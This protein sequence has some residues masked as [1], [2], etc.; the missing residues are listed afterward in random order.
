MILVDTWAWIALADRSDANRGQAK[1]HHR[2][3]TRNRQQ[4]ATTDYV[5]GETITALYDVL[6]PKKARAF[7]QAVLDG[8]DGGTVHF[9]HL[10]P[11]QF[12]RA[13]Q[14][15]QKYHDK[16]AISFVDFTS[17]AVM[18]DLGITE[19]FSGDAHFEHVGLGFQLRP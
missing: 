16:P 13:W 4:Y 8:A 3:F 6:P 9:V 1:E 15:R 11:N 10:S 12:R 19:I 17:M 5:I 14:M 7:I 2:I 18:K